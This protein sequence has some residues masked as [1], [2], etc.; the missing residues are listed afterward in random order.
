MNLIEWDGDKNELRKVS[1]NAI[2]GK[3]YFKETKINQTKFENKYK[4]SLANLQILCYSLFI[5]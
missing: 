1:E 4:I 5:N 2:N 3:V